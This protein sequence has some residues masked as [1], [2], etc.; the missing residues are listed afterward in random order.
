MQA[1]QKACNRFSR[2]T[3]IVFTMFVFSVAALSLLGILAT[4]CA[5]QSQAP[6]QHS[7]T[8][9]ADV[10]H[11]L[12]APLFLL[13]PAPIA[14]GRRIHSV[15]LLPRVGTDAGADT[16]VQDSDSRVLAPVPLLNFNGVGDGFTGPA[17]TF[18]VNSAPPDTNGDVGPNHY[19][20][21]V[22]TDFA[23]F[24]K[25]GTPI[26]GPKPINT[27]WSG[28]GGGCQNNNDGDP[29]VL[30]DPIADRWVVSQFS[31][32]TLPYLECV[33]VSQT[34]DP[35]GAYFRYSFSYGNTD[36]PD[37]PKM[38]VWPDAYYD[39][40]HVFGNSGNTFSGARVCAYDRSKMLLGQTATQ[41]CFNT[42]TTYGGL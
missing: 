42:S 37:Y 34:P 7:P 29:S 17:G 4:D 11:D 26:F 38:G 2:L 33:A 8:I 39:T 20:Q 41:Q 35:T 12:S 13:Q 21:I 24:N 9:D 32:S 5:A 3:A 15:K 36:F 1:S 16:V 30:Y 6:V 18:V 40:Y 22:N 31:V 28:F 14:A 25:T 19:V 23:I 10:H 27:L